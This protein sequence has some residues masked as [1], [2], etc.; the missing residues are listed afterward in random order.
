[1]G[2]PNATMSGY[3][4]VVDDAMDETE[5]TLDLPE[6]ETRRLGARV[7]DLIAGYYRDLDGMPVAH[8]SDPARVEALFADPLPRAGVPADVLLER[9][10]QDVFPHLSHLGHPRFF[11]Y[12]PASSTPVGAYAEAIAA[13]ANVFA[14]SWRA[15]AAAAAMET[16]VLSWFAGMLGLPAGTGGILLSGG[17]MANLSALAAA[18]RA[19]AGAD[20]VRDG[21]AQG[22]APLVAYASRET[23]ASV[24]RAF[25]LLGLGSRHLRRLP[26]DADCRLKVTALE[27]AI[28]EDRA[29]GRRPFCVIANAGTTNTGAVDPLEAVAAVCRR[30]RLWFHVDAAYGGFAILAPAA[31]SL[32]AGIAEAD[33][34]TLDP[35]KWL[36]MPFETGCLLMKDP[37]RLRDAFDLGGDYL[38]DHRGI[39]PVNFH[40]YGPQLTRSFRALKVWMTLSHYGTDRIARVIARTLELA[41]EASALVDAHPRL[42]RLAPTSLGVVCF[43]Y[44]GEDAVNEAL[45]AAVTASGEAFLSSTRLG[46]RFA[47]RLC[48]L[49]HR[50]RRRD[51]LKALELVV[52]EGDRLARA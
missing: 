46:D 47:I 37:A 51:V 41:R 33:S 35:H 15:G 26:V 16:R 29:A 49:N 9:I 18:R 4:T 34:V 24:D 32:F 20:A 44:R 50:T 39:G 48:V 17:S 40:D 6:A 27:Q 38:Q 43:R 3:P 23:H 10:R 45:L 21:M 19:H 13:A 2:L 5:E 52:R 25:S 1:M 31:R 22:T 14:G 8:G 11:A 36:Y 7:A 42:E 30:E 28:A 12:V